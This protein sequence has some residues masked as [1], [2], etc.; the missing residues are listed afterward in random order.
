MYVIS[1]N[2]NVHSYCTFMFGFVIIIMLRTAFNICKKLHFFFFLGKKRLMEN[3]LHQDLAMR[4][5]CPKAMVSNVFLS[6]VLHYY[7]NKGWI[8]FLQD[9][10]ETIVSAALVF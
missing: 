7:L 5:Y 1:S 3:C 10:I 4:F 8:K 9:E 2:I 6:W